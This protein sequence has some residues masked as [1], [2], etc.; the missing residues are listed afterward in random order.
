MA[1]ISDKVA[2]EIARRLREFG[3]PKT[4]AEVIKTELALPKAKRS[5]IGMFAADMYGPGADNG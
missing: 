4:T 3:Y 5:V 1:E 2:E